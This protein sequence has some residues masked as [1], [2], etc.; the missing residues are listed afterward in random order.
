MNYI[1]ELLNIKIG[2]LY[3][4][5][6]IIV[7]PVSMYFYGKYKYSSGANDEREKQ[8]NSLIIEKAIWESKQNIMIENIRKEALRIKVESESKKKEADSISNKEIYKND[9]IDKSGLD[10]LNRRISK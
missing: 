9:C 5:I 7:F 2:I 1:L 10:F 4:L 3:I 8:K 6:L